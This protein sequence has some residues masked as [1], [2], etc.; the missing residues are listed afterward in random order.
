VV[1]SGRLS[2]ERHKQGSITKVGNSY[3]RRL[4]LEAAPNERA[5]PQAGYE[6]ARR[7][8]GHDPLVI[9]CAWRCQRRLHRR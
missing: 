6:L 3:L 1:S 9:E 4:L 5:R 7:Q 8:R 2:G